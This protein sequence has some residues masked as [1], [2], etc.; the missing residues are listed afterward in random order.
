MNKQYEIFKTKNTDIKRKN[1]KFLN[2]YLTTKK[3]QSENKLNISESN[4]EKNSKADTKNLKTSPNLNKV[5]ES[6]F[7]KKKLKKISTKFNSNVNKII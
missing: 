4:L 7:R 2:F 3:L 6:K 1:Y 5:S